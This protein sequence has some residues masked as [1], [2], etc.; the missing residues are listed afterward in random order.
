MAK[1]GER[2]GA[3]RSRWF[4]AR[5]RFRAGWSRRAGD[6]NA[7]GF[8][9]LHVGAPGAAIGG[10]SY[11]VFGGPA[12]AT[13][14]LSLIGI[15]G[16]R[17][18]SIDASAASDLPGRMVS[19]AGNVNGDGFADLLIGAPSADSGGDASAGSSFVVFGSNGGN[20]VTI[21]AS[22]KTATYTDMGGD[23]VTIKV[24]KGTLTADDFTLTGAN[25][26]GGAT[27]RNIDFTDQSELSGANLSVS[28]KP[29][30]IDGVLRRDGLANVGALD[31]GNLSLGK[32]KIGGD[33]GR[34]KLGDSLARFSAKSLT[35]N[36]L[37]TLGL[38]TQGG[39]D[40]STLST[41]TGLLG[42]LS[43]KTGRLVSL[44]IGGSFS[45]SLVTLFGT[46]DPD[47]GKDAVALKR[48]SVAGNLENTRILAGNSPFG[49]NSD[50]SISRVSVGGDW[51]ASSLSA[52]VASGLDGILGTADDLTFPGGGD[53]LI[54]R[55]VSV[56]IKGQALDTSEPGGKFAITAQEVGSVTI[57]KNKLAMQKGAKDSLVAIGSTGDFFVN[58]A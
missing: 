49:G 51:M 34:F 25:A 36:S 8:D 11:V 20:Q 37:G 23:L 44:N 9:D 45:D 52:G 55:I 6:V 19:T 22:G 50:V 2:S 4:A 5:G 16:S 35:V 10:K 14:N 27:L 24:N 46:N 43:V 40:S 38:D 17:A 18:F 26:L 33:L 39:V 30:V 48:L 42:K 58:E 7:D 21:G 41:F 56:V 15:D 3:K 1:G 57:G 12:T 32:V 29:Q 53:A 28:A 13:G 31:A 54:S 47:S